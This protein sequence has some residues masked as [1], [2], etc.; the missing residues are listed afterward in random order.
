[1]QGPRVSDPRSGEIIESHIYW[2]HN[3]MNIFKH[4][5]A[6][7]VGQLDP[8]AQKADWD[9]ALIGRLIR[10]VAAHEVG[11]TLGLLHNFGSSHAVPVEKLRDKDYIKKYGHSPSIMEYARFNYVAQPGDGIDPEDFVP[12]INDYDNWVIEWGYKLIPDTKSE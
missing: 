11:H 3:V 10:Y 7:Q 4:L 8:R 6:I 5:Y 9:E 1:A 2:Y 12:R